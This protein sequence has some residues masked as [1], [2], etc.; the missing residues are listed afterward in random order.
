MVENIVIGLVLAIIVI[1]IIYILSIWIYK[2]AP[3]NMGFIRTGFLGTK[4]CLGRGAIV[5]PVFHEVT[6]VSLE[7]IKLIVSRSRDQAILTADKIRIDVVTELYTHVGR[8]VDDL[9]TASRS[10]GDKTF[11]S[12]KVRNLLEAKVVSA[13][14]S[15]AATKSLS[16]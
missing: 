9:L 2:R 5:L 6:W 13:L 3:A 11:D 1:A 8:T 12:D 4:V 10:L 14:R 15:Y 16:E 7:T